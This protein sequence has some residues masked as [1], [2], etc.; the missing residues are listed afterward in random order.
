MEFRIADTFTDSLARLTGDEQKSVKTAA[1]DLQLNPAHPSLQ[2]HKLDRAKDVNFWSIRVSRDIRL[3]VHRTNSSLLLC[4]VAHHDAAYQ[5]AER[6]KL[7]THPKTGAA[8]LVEIRERV[9]EIAVPKYVEAPVPAAIKSLFFAT[10]S[11]AELLQFGVPIEWLADVRGANEDTLLEIATHLPGEAAEALLNLATGVATATPSVVT[12]SD[13][14]E[15]PDAQRRF[16]VM[17]NIE[18]LQLALDYPWE[19]WAVFLHPAQRQL[20]ERD[21]N[22]PVKVAGSAGTG[23]TIVAL[24]RAVHL[25]RAYPDSRV[26]L[27][28]F[29]DTLANAL[30]T[31]LRLLIGSQPRLGEQIEVLSMKAVGMR[32]YELN[33]GKPTMASAEMIRRMMEESSNATADHKFSLRFLLSEW[34]QVVDAWQLSSWEE[35]RDVTRLGRKTRLK[36]PQRSLL[37]S[38]F[39]DV[40]ARLRNNK[41]MTEAGMFDRLAVHYSNGA[42]SPFDF[43]VVDEAQDVS[44][45]Q[46]RLLAA[47]GGKRRNG[48]FFAGDTG[49][50]IFQQ[51]FSWKSLGVDLRGRSTTLKVNYRTSHQIRTQADRLLDSEVS[52]VD[53]N[54]EDRSGTVSLFDGPVPQII[55]VETE[56]VEQSEVAKWLQKRLVAGLRPDEIVVFVRSAAELPRAEQAAVVAGLPFR[57]LDAH[58]ETTVGSLSL[59]TMHLA[60]GLEFRAVAVMACDDE[61]IPLQERIET[62]TDPSELEDV[63]NTERQLLYVACTRARDCLLLTSVGSPSEF[64]QDMQARR[65]G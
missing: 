26:L 37:W 41:L 22:G 6:R 50:R 60:K 64:L 47:L 7:E 49:Q 46:L 17:K 8:Q 2:L 57:V 34:E 16:R 61:V 39:D 1:F 36:E 48:L 19:K 4:Y 29:S 18:E 35:Y 30:R 51:P 40:R 62:A 15:H 55:N 31:R 44:I 5:W 27:T 52:D 20:V 9:Q 58:A 25:A 45:T 13:P 65:V 11:D 42:V 59:S 14:F 32:L 10:L 33:L 28:T 23:K 43:A 54:L 12:V 38:I 3:I 56:T 53:G 63:Y 24:H 21:F